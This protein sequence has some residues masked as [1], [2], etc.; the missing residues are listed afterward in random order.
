MSGLATDGTEGLEP[1]DGHDR[2]SENTRSGNQV[3]SVGDAA[4]IDIDVSCVDKDGNDIQLPPVRVRVEQLDK[5]STSKPSARE[6]F[7]KAK[8]RIKSIFSKSQ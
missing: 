3:L 1:D 6:R 5:P 7:E 8:D 2:D 4:F